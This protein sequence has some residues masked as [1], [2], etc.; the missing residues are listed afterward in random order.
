M[1]YDVESIGD[2]WEMLC[3]AYSGLT[4]PLGAVTSEVIGTEVDLAEAGFVTFGFETGGGLYQVRSP[5]PE[6]TTAGAREALASAGM[7]RSAYSGVDG[8]EYDLTA[9]W[10]TLIPTIFPSLVWHI[11]VD[12][13]TITLFGTQNIDRMTVNR[14]AIGY[15]ST[16]QVYDDGGILR[17]SGDDE[18]VTGYTSWVQWWVDPGI[19]LY[20]DSEQLWTL[21]RLQAPTAVP[22]D[23][24]GE[25]IRALHDAAESI[26][27]REPGSVMTRRG[28][29]IIDDLG[30]E[31][32]ELPPREPSAD[33]AMR[34]LG[35]ALAAR[36]GAGRT[37]WRD[38]AIA[39]SG[40]LVERRNRRT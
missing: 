14:F 20:P 31:P 19:P 11:N 26:A 9:L 33:S 18:V 29:S 2:G 40:A 38:R 30:G 37:I 16:P 1:S 22:I 25:D 24:E 17:F 34:R 23:I 8:V 5:M 3:D 12:L 32:I 21:A 35:S 28:R 4:T 13:T 36:H 39:V 10:Q 7:R 15:E 27:T 6:D